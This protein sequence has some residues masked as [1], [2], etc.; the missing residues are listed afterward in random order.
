MYVEKFW[1]IEK[2]FWR[3]FYFSTMG[4]LFCIKRLIRTLSIDENE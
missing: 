2:F 1:Y 4:W 3:F